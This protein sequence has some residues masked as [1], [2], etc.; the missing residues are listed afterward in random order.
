MLDRRRAGIGAHAGQ[1]GQVGDRC[2]GGRD[3]GGHAS[4]RARPEEPE[5]LRPEH[6][7]RGVVRVHR[8]CDQRG[9]QS[10]P[11]DRTA[12]RCDQHGEG[13]AEQQ[14]D[15]ERVRP[16]LGRVEDHERVERHDR[17]SHQPGR[18][19]EEP[20]CQQEGERDR[21]QP[22]DQ[23]REPDELGSRA[24]LRADPGEHEVERR[25]DLR[26]ALHQVKHVGEAVAVDDVDRRQLVPEGRVVEVHQPGDDAEDDS[27][28]RHPLEEPSF[29][30]LAQNA[31]GT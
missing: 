17:G 6:E 30:Q 16:R 15:R 10:P 26:V 11:S 9:V 1:P 19:P 21:G 3:Q 12:L 13:A 2:G 20:P 27:G 29:G 18:V 22:G 14:G 7:R 25:R 24:E 8:Q 31:M 28:G 5:E 23:S 4:R